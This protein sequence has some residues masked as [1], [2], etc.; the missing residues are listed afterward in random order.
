MV[1][2]ISRGGG[3]EIVPKWTRL[4]R[5]ERESELCSISSSSPSLYFWSVVNIAMGR[6]AKVHKRAVST[7][8]PLCNQQNAYRR[9][10]QAKKT[11]STT[12]VA[13]STS[14]PTISAAAERTQVFAQ[15]KKKAGLKVKA[16]EKGTPTETVIKGSGNLLGGADYVDLMMGTRKQA[17]QEAAKL[18]KDAKAQSL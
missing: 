15:S 1:E 4:Y 8:K 18:H 14:K 13:T 9:S 16:K 6:S 7:S 12:S 5:L 3:V 17:R 2:Q 11:T 10:Q